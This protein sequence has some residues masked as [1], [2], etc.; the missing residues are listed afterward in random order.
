MP[1]P[2][3]NALL[4]LACV[5]IA[6]VGA[7]WCGDAR[8][9]PIRAIGGPP[10]SGECAKPLIGYATMNGGTIGG[11]AGETVTVSTAVDLQINASADRPLTIVV[12]G[13]ITMTAGQ[14]SVKADKTI[15]GMGA[16]SGMS[17]GGL[18]LSD[19]HNVILR[20]LVI[21]KAVGTDAVTI[22]SAH[23]IWIDHCDLSSDKD[24][25][26]DYYDGLVDII[27]ASDFVTVSW[28]RLHDHYQTDVIG[29]DDGDT[30]DAGHLNVTFEHNLFQST[31]SHN[32]SI[33]FGNLHALNNYYLTIDSTGLSS[34]MNAN[35]LAEGNY[36]DDVKV[37]LTTHLASPT[38][39]YMNSQ[40]NDF[41]NCP[42]SCP[43]TEIGASQVN[44]WTPEYSGYPVE[45]AAQ[46][47]DS[48][49]KCVGVGRINL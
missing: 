21:E 33:R 16:A 17:G 28:T 34:R 14:I 31:Y 24:H 1:R 15:V 20:N 2:R 42:D 5:G 23:N 6:C 26:K 19:S 49:M 48:V 41:V 9:T 40:G 43:G 30:G 37:P 45:D 8:L 11:A 29:A 22:S 4:A 36:F 27:P 47:P 44:D 46:V 10:G 12:S 3:L 7:G 18:N 38:D 25:G 32:P 39:G 13:M 35:V